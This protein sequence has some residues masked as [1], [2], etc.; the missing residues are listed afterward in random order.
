MRD[1]FLI[2]PAVILI[3][4]GVVMFFI[5]FCGCIGALRENIR[6]LKTVIDITDTLLILALCFASAT[7]AHITFNPKPSPTSHVTISYDYV[8]D[9]VLIFVSLLIIVLLQPDIGL[10]HPAVHSNSGLLL[11]RSGTCLI[12]TILYITLVRWFND[13][14]LLEDYMCSPVLF[15]SAT[16][17]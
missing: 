7:V 11:L 9:W 15:H 3:V 10:P 12:L 17:D 5:T 1:T 4:V 13:I 8:L 14:K 6:L 2:D 16:V